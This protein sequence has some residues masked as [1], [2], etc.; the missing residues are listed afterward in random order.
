MN[1]WKRYV[2]TAVAVWGVVLSAATLA[3]A[4]PAIYYVDRVI[5]SGTVTGFIET[6]GL[7]G[8]LFAADFLDWNLV[9]SDG[10]S[11]FNLLGPLSGNNSTV[12]IQGADTEAFGPDLLF[13]FS[14]IDNGIFLFQQGL[15]S[16]NHYYCD[17]SQP[18]P[19]FPGETVV[20]I[21]VSVGYQN[22]PDLRGV[23]VI[24]DEAN[25]AP[26]PGT[27]VLALTGVAIG[28]RSRRLRSFLIDGPPSSKR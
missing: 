25:A 7:N 11:T 16:G 19:C 22:N 6:D 23:V 2:F 21:N 12:F 10:T 5:G 1:F 26:E 3:S 4:T 9:L 28:F 15:F 20:P 8:V 13:N 14:G 24:G 27:F 18:G 17:S